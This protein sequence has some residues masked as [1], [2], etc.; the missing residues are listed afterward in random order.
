ME[1]S[2]CFFT[3][4]NLRLQEQGGDVSIKTPFKA[5]EHTL[6]I[7]LRAGLW[8]DFS[9]T[10]KIGGGITHFWNI[11]LSDSYNWEFGG[12]ISTGLEYKF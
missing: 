9:A 11:P 12:V 7:G 6:G 8:D 1:M 10:F 5:M 2:F 4:T 3:I